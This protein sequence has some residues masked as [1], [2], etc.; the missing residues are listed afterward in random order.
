MTGPVRESTRPAVHASRAGPLTTRGIV[1]TL[2]GA[3][4]VGAFLAYGGAF[5]SGNLPLAP[6][7]GLVIGLA[8]AG[9]MIGMACFRLAGRLPL[10]NTGLWRQAL[11]G[12]LIMIAPMALVIWVVNSIAIGRPLPRAALPEMTISVA[13]VCIAMS[14]LAVAF[15]RG[16][17]LMAMTAAAG[18]GGPPKF[19]DRL[20]PKLR[21][22]EIYA[23]EAE[24]HY[25][26]LHTSKGQDLI[27]MRLADAIS[28]LQGIEGAQVHRS[29]WVARAAIAEAKRGDGRADLTLKDGAEVPVS[30]TYARQLREAGWI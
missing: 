14:F 24:D 29:W 10:F 8:C 20:P 3:A 1:R 22:A 11:G 9:S 27:L 16:A 6:R 25:L 15:N 7:F 23:V 17:E 19:L 30:R 13:V 2:I 4:V 5:G 18:D 28:E 12:G 21:G 26:R